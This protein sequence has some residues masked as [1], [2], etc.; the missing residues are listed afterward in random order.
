[1][2]RRVLVAVVAAALVMAATASQDLGPE[3]RHS[4]VAEVERRGAAHNPTATAEDILPG[5]Q[6]RF[7]DMKVYYPTGGV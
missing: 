3:G 2:Y 7:K 6:T 1:M 5:F 4:P